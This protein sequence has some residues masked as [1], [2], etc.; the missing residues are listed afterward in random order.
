[1]KLVSCESIGRFQE[2]RPLG[3]I[4]KSDAEQLCGLM[5]SIIQVAAQSDNNCVPIDLK[6]E[7]ARPQL[8]PLTALSGRESQNQGQSDSAHQCLVPFYKIPP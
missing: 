7:E 1:M 2:A 4:Q 6:I 5:T 8:R 3:K